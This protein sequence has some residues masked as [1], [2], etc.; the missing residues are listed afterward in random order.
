MTASWGR[1]RRG[2]EAGFTLLELLIAMT[3]L[4]L[5]MT[6][7]FGGLRF[8]VRVWERS[9]A[10]S[11]G[12]DAV[13]LAQTLLRRD[14]EQ[15]YPMFVDDDPTRAHVDFSGSPQAIAFLGPEP[16]VLGPGGRARIRVLGR[17]QGADVALAVQ[18][19][20]ELS[21]AGASVPEEVLLT[22]L[23]SVEFGYFGKRRDENA[24]SWHDRW[25]NQTRL[26]LLIRIRAEFPE[27]SRRTWPELIV[28]PR[29]AADVGCLYDVLTSYC[30]GR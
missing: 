4:G 7:I 11:S 12:A 8:G 10:Y 21:N 16:A 6:M 28:A 23:K 3:L 14:L 19:Q 1:N 5:L 9:E 26:P 29:L 20:S 13:R 15:A 18:M 27:R 24:A 17:E 22:G 25:D 30:R 2:S